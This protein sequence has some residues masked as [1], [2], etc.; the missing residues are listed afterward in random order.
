M[1]NTSTQEGRDRRRAQ[2]D[3]QEVDRLMKK[4]SKTKSLGVAGILHNKFGIGDF[5]AD[6]FSN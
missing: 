2:L 3:N 1:I 5:G 6:E 4:Y